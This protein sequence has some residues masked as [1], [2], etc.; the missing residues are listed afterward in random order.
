M[1]I[2]IQPKRKWLYIDWRG[3]LHYRDLL[4]FLVR[5][6]FVSRYKQTILGPLWFIVQP[7]LMTLVFTVIF[8]RVAGISTDGL[9]PVLFYLCGLLAWTYFANCLKANSTT[10]TD[11]AH[12][13][14]KVYFPRLVVPLANTISNLFA[15][16]IQLATFLVFY[17]Y[18]KYFT[19]SETVIRPNLLILTMPLLLLGTAAISLG[20]RLWISALTAKYRDLKFLMEFLIQLLM[21]ATPVIY[22][23]SVIPQKWRLLAALNPMAPIVE[24]YR[25]AFFGTASLSPPYLLMSAVTAVVVLL[26]GVLVFNRTERVFIDTV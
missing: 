12:L 11:N 15:F 3:L 13:F 24:S 9:P 1:E 2:I 16:A 10:F 26:T 4:F 20:V 23:V 21:Y 18:F 22:P 17:F 6:D 8:S 14:G 5:R 7:L 19:R 25:Y